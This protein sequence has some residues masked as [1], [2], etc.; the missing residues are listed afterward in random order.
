MRNTMRSA[1]GW[2]KGSTT[3]TVI[4][5][6]VLVALGIGAGIYFAKKKTDNGNSNSSNSNTTSENTNG[7]VSG[8]TSDTR[9]V[10]STPDAEI[11]IFYGNTC[12]H[13]KNLNAA[14]IASDLDKLVKLQHLEVYANKSNLE[15]MK[16]KLEQCK[17]LSDSD[18]GGVPFMYAPDKCL[19]G[20]TPIVDYLKSKVN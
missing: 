7:Q 16:Q 10:V 15:L 14:I 1:S 11:M 6:I 20:S 13:C 18:K 8:A 3:S 5:I 19:V 9:E 4:I 17:D 2:K 12:P